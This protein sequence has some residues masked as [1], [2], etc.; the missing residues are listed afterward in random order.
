M[1]ISEEQK[2]VLGTFNLDK[3]PCLGRGGSAQVVL[4]FDRKDPSS[5]VAVKIISFESGKQAMVDQF[6]DEVSALRCLSHDRVMSL[7]TYASTPRQGF[8][9][10]KHYPHGTVDKSFP[11]ESSVALGY[12]A[13]V[14]R[15]LDYIH[16]LRIYHQDVKPANIFLDDDGRAVLGDFGLARRLKDGEKKV[17][18][19]VSTCGFYGPETRTGRCMCPFKATSVELQLGPP[20]WLWKEQLKDETANI[21]NAASL[22]CDGLKPV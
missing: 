22:R 12:V 1:E 3:G 17:T 8:I 10:L 21:F 14:A 16:R 15:A 11:V 20:A 7:V 13:D 4:A 2:H 9:V 18:S 6:H 5:K 19:W